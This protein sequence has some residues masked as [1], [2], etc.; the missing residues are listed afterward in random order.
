MVNE[1]GPYDVYR[2]SEVLAQDIRVNIFHIISVI[3]WFEGINGQPFQ[4]FMLK[5]L[6]FSP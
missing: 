4:P 3:N 1:N 5:G 6:L 2:K